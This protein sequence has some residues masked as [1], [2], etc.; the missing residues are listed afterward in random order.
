MFRLNQLRYVVCAQ[1]KGTV[2]RNKALQYGTH[3]FCGDYCIL[4]WIKERRGQ[5][6]PR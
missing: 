1:C 6:I 3:L 4:D 5:T 2:E